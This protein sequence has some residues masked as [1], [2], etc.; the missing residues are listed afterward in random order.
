MSD[1]AIGSIPA[2]GSSSRMKCGWGASARAILQR[3]RSPPRGPRPR[4]DFAA[5]PPAPGERHRWRPPQMGYRELGEQS[6]EHGLAQIGRRLG[7]FEDRADVLFD[8]EAAKY[9]G[10]LREITDAKPGA[11]VHR[12]IGDVTAVQA[13]RTG[14]GGNQT[15]DD[16]KAGGLSRAVGAG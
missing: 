13:D 14:V 11:P 3:R 15:G 16:V 8:S 9:R 7:N 10:L 6:V 12:K 2:S 1:T 4:G 5:P